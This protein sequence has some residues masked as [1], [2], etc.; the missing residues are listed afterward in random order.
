MHPNAVADLTEGGWLSAKARDLA[1]QA[2]H[3][4]MVP[5]IGTLCT[6]EVMIHRS[7]FGSLRNQ[8]KTQNATEELYSLPDQR[9]CHSLG[10]HQASLQLFLPTSFFLCCYSIA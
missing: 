5:L 4:S 3:K 9:I 1:I 6:Q 7:R 2:A 10:C 8:R